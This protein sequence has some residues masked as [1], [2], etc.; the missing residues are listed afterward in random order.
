MGHEYNPFV[1]PK[2]MAPGPY[3]LK[4]TNKVGS[5]TLDIGFTITIP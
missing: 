1:V 5:D 4:V 3:N 2:K